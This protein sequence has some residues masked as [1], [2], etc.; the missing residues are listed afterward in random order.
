MSLKIEHD[1]N[2]CGYDADGKSGRC[3]CNDCISNIVDE[4]FQKGKEEGIR[5][6]ENN[7]K[8]NE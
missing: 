2:E 4:A 5:I 3:L 8:N 7:Q 1:C 6:G